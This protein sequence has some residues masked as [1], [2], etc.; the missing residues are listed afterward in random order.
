MWLYDKIID[1]EKA[2]QETNHNLSIW[3]RGDLSDQP[4]IGHDS[5]FLHSFHSILK[6]EFIKNGN[7]DIDAI[8]KLAEG[9]KSNRVFDLTEGISPKTLDVIGK[10]DPALLQKFKNAVASEETPDLERKIRMF[11]TLFDFSKVDAKSEALDFLTKDFE[12]GW[13]EK[14]VPFAKTEFI[15]DGKL[16]GDAFQEFMWSL[17]HIK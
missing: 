2:A 10:H 17:R 15:E 6:P 16:G 7:V 8:Y 14:F 13:T 1:K 11:D 3:L 5:T 9:F 12:D 4:V